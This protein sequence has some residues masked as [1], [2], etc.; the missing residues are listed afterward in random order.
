MNHSRVVCPSAVGR[1]ARR[2]VSMTSMKRAL[3][4][5]GALALVIG[6]AGV[7][8]A[9]D[10]AATPTFAKDVAPILYNNC[11]ICHRPGEVAPMSLITYQ[12][13]R[14]WAKAMKD[15]VVA[16]EMPPWGADP[17]AGKFKNDRSLSQKDIDTIVAW[18]SGGA[19]KGDDKD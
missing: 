19:P 11:V 6:A 12:D 17:T 14:P 5:V 4:T 18:V 16:R 3:V 15:K 13:A 7:A 1:L 10:P 8:S 2:S 9:A